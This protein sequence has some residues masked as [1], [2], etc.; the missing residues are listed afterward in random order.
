MLVTP[1]GRVSVT[2]TL[3]AGFGPA[4]LAVSVQVIVL[5]A[6]TGFGVAVFVIA[7]FAAATTCVVA[8]QVL[9]VAIPL[10]TVP[11][12]VFVMA[13][14]TV[15]AVPVIMMSGAVVFIGIDGRVH[16][17]S[18]EYVQDQPFPVAL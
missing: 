5:P 4:L 6:S 2:T 11:T 3:V 8:V 1:A 15:G 7:T 16:V 9:Y 13:P 14:A 17:T 12:H 18:V 10:V